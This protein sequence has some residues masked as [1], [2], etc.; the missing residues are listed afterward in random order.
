MRRPPPR[1]YAQ[2]Q[3]ADI[4]ATGSQYVVFSPESMNSVE[5]VDTLAIYA[6][7]ITSPKI[8]EGA[9]IKSPQELF[10]SVIQRTQELFPHMD[11]VLIVRLFSYLQSISFVSAE[12]YQE[13]L[14]ACVPRL[15]D[16]SIQQ[17]VRLMF[18]VCVVSRRLTFEKCSFTEACFLRMKFDEL[19]ESTPPRVVAKLVVSTAILASPSKI[20]RILPKLEGLVS[21]TLTNL[22]PD[23]LQQVAFGLGRLGTKNTDL[24]DHIT[25]HALNVTPISDKKTYSSL[26]ISLHRLEPSSPSWDAFKKIYR[27][28][29]GLSPW[30]AP[31]VSNIAK[32]LP[33]ESEILLRRIRN[34]LVH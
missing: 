31:H 14:N 10:P 34:A 7:R 19:G 13:L 27:D 11:P 18:S 20:E 28:H 23:H 25:M 17:L 16:L 33:S 2:K 26:L 30:E 32:C 5:L 29:I 3:I 8:K 22:Q 6:G 1:V 21:L 4:R 24:V 9:L 12:Q 15:V